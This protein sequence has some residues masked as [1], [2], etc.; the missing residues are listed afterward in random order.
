VFRIGSAIVVIM[1][2]FFSTSQ[3]FPFMEIF[4]LPLLSI[5]KSQ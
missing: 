5:Y 2:L 4:F 3:S 1:S